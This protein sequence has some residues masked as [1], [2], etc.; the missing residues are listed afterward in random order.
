MTKTENHSGAHSLKNLLTFF[1][2][3][4]FWIAIYGVVIFYLTRI[5]Y[6]SINP[7]VNIESYRYMSSTVNYLNITSMLKTFIGSWLIFLIHAY[8]SKTYFNR[9]G[10]IKIFSFLAAL[11]IIVVVTVFVFAKSSLPGDFFKNAELIIRYKEIKD[12][13]ELADCTDE[14]FNKMKQNFV[15]IYTELRNVMNEEGISSLDRDFKRLSNG[16]DPLV[17]S[18]VTKTSN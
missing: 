14:N 10:L 12:M 9:H 2:S 4:A 6:V 15:E 16:L 7:N 18:C 11:I 8:I 17:W 3:S 1:N 5:T 13:K